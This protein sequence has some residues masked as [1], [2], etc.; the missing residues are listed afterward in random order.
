MKIDVHRIKLIAKA[1]LVDKKGNREICRDLNESSA[2]VS[3]YCKYFD[4]CCLSYED[5]SELNDHDFLIAL[6]GKS[7]CEYLEFPKIILAKFGLEWP[8]NR[9]SVL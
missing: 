1:Y 3:R 4:L 6:K 8:F 2:T 7:D 9:R 5:L